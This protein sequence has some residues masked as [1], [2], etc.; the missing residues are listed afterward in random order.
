MLSKYYKKPAP[1]RIY[2]RCG[3]WFSF[4]LNLKAFEQ[5][6]DYCL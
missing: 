4:L 2:I 1:L 3:G 6:R 5:A